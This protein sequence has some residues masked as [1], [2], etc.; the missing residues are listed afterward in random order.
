V[1]RKFLLFT[2]N[3]NKNL[4]FIVANAFKYYVAVKLVFYVHFKAVKKSFYLFILSVSLLA[5]THKQQL[6]RNCTREGTFAKNNI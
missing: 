1:E 4:L 5:Y 2:L 3:A 6:K